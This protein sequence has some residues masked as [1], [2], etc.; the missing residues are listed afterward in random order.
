MET[1][2][3]QL[4]P[5]E[6]ESL[7]L[8]NNV[9][10]KFKL[11]R[12]PLCYIFLQFSLVLASL[13]SIYEIGNLYQH[14]EILKC[15]D[16]MKNINGT[17]V[18]LISDV[19]VFG[20]SVGS[21]LRKVTNDLYM[22]QLMNN[23]KSIVKPSYTFHLGDAMEE[24]HLSFTTEDQY[25]SYAKRFKN[26]VGDLDIN[27]PGNHD[28]GWPTIDYLKLSYYQ[29]YIGNDQGNTSLLVN[30]N[31]MSFGYVNS[32][33]NNII[34]PDTDVVLSHYPFYSNNNNLSGHLETKSSNTDYPIYPASFCTNKTKRIFF[35]HLHQFKIE[36]VN[37]YIGTFNPLKVLDVEVPPDFNK[38]PGFA[39]W[40]TYNNDVYLCL[41]PQLWENYWK[42]SILPIMYL[43]YVVI[44]IFYYFK[45]KQNGY[46]LLIETEIN[47]NSF[48]IVVHTNYCCSSLLLL[49][50]KYAI[51]LSII[52]NFIMML[53]FTILICVLEKEYLCIVSSVIMTVMIAEILTCN[54]EL[55]NLFIVVIF[56]LVYFIV[57]VAT[58]SHFW[59]NQ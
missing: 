25:Q 22:K 32:M 35:G 53:M 57:Y 27:V 48:G 43:M 31:L 47:S 54:H 12:R 58:Q 38:S 17:S 10:E 19:H 16:K 50:K 40:N 34:C 39:V 4:N 7:S 52:K 49:Y 42:I 8:A 18:L 44:T 3:L 30:H 29:K 15:D 6:D 36:E 26:V 59:Y 23:V 46:H 20:N 24:A 56:I 2:Y 51:F 21:W 1:S 28:V 5:I 41:L 11:C 9:I 37:V 45:Y 33:Y 55:L 13:G 14:N